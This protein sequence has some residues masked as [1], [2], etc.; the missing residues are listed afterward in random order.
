MSR[1]IPRG[2]RCRATGEHRGLPPRG[3]RR[4]Q[5][6]GHRPPRRARARRGPAGARR[7]VPVPRR[8]RHHGER[9]RPARADDQAGDGPARACTSRSTATSPASPTPPTGARSW[10]CRRSAGAR[11]SASP[12]SLVPEIEQARRRRHRRADGPAP[13]ARTSRRSG[14]AGR[15]RRGRARSRR[16]PARRRARPRRRCAAEATIRPSSRQPRTRIVSPGNTTPANRAEKPPTAVAS[17]PSS[18]SVS[19]RSTMP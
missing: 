16:A 1:R 19:S 3:V 5:R 13:C 9:A 15:L 18:A 10:C 2:R 7:G 11:C 6:P 17:P 8:H 12:R 14:G 4:A